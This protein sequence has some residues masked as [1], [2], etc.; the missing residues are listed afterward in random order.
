LKVV[1]FSLAPLAV[2][3]GAAGGVAEGAEGGLVRIDAG[4]TPAGGE[5]VPVRAIARRPD[6]IDGGGPEA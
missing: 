4:Y 3:E 6:T 1:A 2:V 5:A